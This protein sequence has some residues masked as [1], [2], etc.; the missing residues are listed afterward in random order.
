MS[1]KDRDFCKLKTSERREGEK[2][3]EQYHHQQLHPWN[4]VQI[5]LKYQKQ[6][7][8]EGEMYCIYMKGNGSSSGGPEL[9]W[10]IVRSTTAC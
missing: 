3:Q 4:F 6:I 7:R 1:I 5:S 10:V 9:V 8:R 2:G